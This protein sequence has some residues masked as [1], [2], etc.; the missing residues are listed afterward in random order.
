MIRELKA[1]RLLLIICFSLLSAAVEYDGLWFLGFNHQSEIFKGSKGLNNRKYLAKIINRK[2]IAVQ[3]IGSSVVAESYIYPNQYYQAEQQDIFADINCSTPN[4]K[5][6]IL[7]HTDGDKT[8]D[9]A[10]I[11]ADDIEKKSNIKVVTKI[12]SMSKPQLW[13]KA[14]KKSE[15]DIFLLGFKAD[16]NGTEDTFIEP[17][18]SSAGYANFMDYQNK[19]VDKLIDEL[20][21]ANNEQKNAILKTLDN[22]LKAEV[23]LVP[24]FYI[25]K[26]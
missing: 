4:I 21:N 7:H 18:Y 12:Y 13:E 5:Q 19:N 6:I 15:F 23:V 11:I 9:I 22:I 24:L 10:E 20:K 17:L 14:L 8:R 25:E 2:K 26:I 16:Y 1:C 3:I